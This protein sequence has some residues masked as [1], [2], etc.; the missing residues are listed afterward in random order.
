MR[1]SRVVPLIALA[2]LSMTLL[3][4]SNAGAK[5]SCAPAKH[6]GGEWR[7]MPGGLN[8]HRNQTAEK[9]IGVPEAVTLAPEWTFSANTATGVATNEITGYPIVA[10]GC[11]YVG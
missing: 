3:P 4:G 6:S 7:S 8:G 5:A 11:I 9:K 1:R 10:D 2:T